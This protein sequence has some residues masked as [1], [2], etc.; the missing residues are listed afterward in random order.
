M[1]SFEPLHH[2]NG[3]ALLIFQRQ[4]VGGKAHHEIGCLLQHK[5]NA[6]AQAIGP[7]RDHQIASLQ[8]KD[9]QV[10]SLLP[11]RHFELGEPTG[12]QIK[13]GMHPPHHSERT[14]AREMGPIDEQDASPS[15]S[16]QPGGDRCRGR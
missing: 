12:Q 7:I 11:I 13:G 9:L 8:V 16:Q 15:C 10:F 1:A 4:I 14:W 3:L 5:D 6:L 2:R